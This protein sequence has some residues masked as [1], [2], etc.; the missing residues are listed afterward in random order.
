MPDCQDLHLTSHCEEDEV[1][2]TVS[3]DA[4]WVTI[5][6]TPIGTPPAES[7]IE[8]CVYTTSDHVR[9]LVAPDSASEYHA[10]A[11]HT[12]YFPI[13]ANCE[14]V[15][16]VACTGIGGTEFD[17]EVCL[18]PPSYCAYG[19][20]Q[21]SDSQYITVITAALVD[22]AIVLLGGGPLALL[23]FDTLIGA[24]ILLGD[25]CGSPPPAVPTF[26]SDDFI[27]G[28][29]IWSPGSFDKRMQAFRAAVWNFY[30]ECI[31]APPGDPDPVPYPD[32]P[33]ISL[34]FGTDPLPL[35][36]VCSNEDICSTLNAM[37][38]QLAAMNVQLAYARRDITLIQRQGVPFGYVPGPLHT[39]LT[40]VGEITVSDILA[41]SVQFTTIPSQ[42]PHIDADPDTYFGLGWLTLGTADGFLHSTK[43]SKNPQL[44][45]P[46]SGEITRVGYELAV[47]VVANIQEFV[48]EP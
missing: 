27:A 37:M 14:S 10:Y 39:G 44:L 34:P 35:P 32:P 8:Y 33:P 46:V 9:H 23:A 36:I 43:L 30:C 6:V 20:K 3:A 18:G 22:V 12:H 15:S 25:L 16:H 26:T 28:T 19:T 31:P 38:R 42:Y 1:F 47:G 11:A 2:F 7:V 17:V 24:P 21:T 5:T 41:L 29:Q 48:R 40:G 13:P 4:Q 45:E